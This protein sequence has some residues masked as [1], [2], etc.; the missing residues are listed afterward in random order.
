MLIIDA[1]ELRIGNLVQYPLIGIL[2][3]ETGADI[4]SVY[5]AAG[6]P[7]PLTS[8]WLERCG[9]VKDILFENQSPTYFLGDFF[10]DSSTFQP[11]DAGFPIA[12][13]KIQ[14]LHQL[15]NLYFA[16]TGEELTITS[17]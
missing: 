1:K 5:E 14:Y 17:L 6:T 11:T 10:I 16:L 12:K 9:F 2:P 15:Q 8:E 3:I 13:Y 4:D 7:I